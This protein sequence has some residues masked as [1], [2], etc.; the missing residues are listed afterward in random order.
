MQE[1][2]AHDGRGYSGAVVERRNRRLNLGEASSIGL[3]EGM[4]SFTPV[5]IARLG[6]TPLE[7][8]LLSSI[9]GLVGLV[10]AT[11]AATIVRRRPNIVRT[12]S[13]LRLVGYL[14]YAVIAIIVLALPPELA[15]PAI[16][17]TWGIASIPDTLWVVATPTVIE[18]IAGP[19]GRVD[20]LAVRWSLIEVGSI[21]SSVGA[22]AV[23]TA[24][25]LPI[26][27]ALVLSGAAIMSVVAFNFAR[28]YRVAT[29]V[30]DA[31]PAAE[32]P[33]RVA[34]SAFQVG[35]FRQH[36]EVRVLLLGGLEAMPP[37]VTLLFVRVMQLEDRDIG[38]L[39]AAQ[40]AGAIAGYLAWRRI[41]ASGPKGG[42]L[43][44]AATAV[45]PYPIALALT[46]SW[47]VVAL[48]LAWAGVARAGLSLG[49]WD[50]SMRAIPVDR[51]LSFVGVLYSIDFAI[52]LVVPIVSATVAQVA[53]I[54][55]ALVMS[56]LVIGSGAVVLWARR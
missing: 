45:A 23:L 33:W 49:L 14:R 7:V 19:R 20:L 26:G 11:P 30:T 48:I 6:G 50:A 34:R 16:L 25:G 17:L 55:V 31:G 39:L 13:R 51:R 53:G 42:I 27:Y 43:V 4:A 15:I 9:T 28:R 10:L 47:P 37:L 8:G 3:T 56:G 12:Y 2:D 24:F 35:P 5:L 29:T 18:G 41:A 38:V 54:P 32:K 40:R 44:L 1:R 46:P 36:I 52:I 22:G 21:I